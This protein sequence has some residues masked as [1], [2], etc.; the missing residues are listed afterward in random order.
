M[1]TKEK[2]QDVP[3]KSLKDNSMSVTGENKLQ[4]K[5]NKVGPEEFEEDKSMDIR[6]KPQPLKKKSNAAKEEKK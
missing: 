4:Q 6:M 5:E 1:K 3:D 2:K